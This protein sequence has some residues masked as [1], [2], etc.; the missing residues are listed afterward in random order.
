[1]VCDSHLI[2]LDK[3]ADHRLV[4]LGLISLECK[5]AEQ[6]S[7]A[8]VVQEHQLQHT[9]L[10][11]KME[12]LHIIFELISILEQLMPSQFC[13][14]LYLVFLCYSHPVSIRSIRHIDFFR[15]RLHNFLL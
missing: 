6:S 15:R 7:S 4:H 11:V 14:V 1:M 2:C 5:V 3:V 10:S 12:L 9:L 8:L 13:M